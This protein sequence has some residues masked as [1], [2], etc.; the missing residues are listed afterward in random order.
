MALLNIDIRKT[1]K[2]SVGRNTPT[3]KFSTSGEDWICKKL[4][5]L[6]FDYHLGYY[7]TSV[8][9]LN[10]FTLAQPIEPWLLLFDTVLSLTYNKE[11]I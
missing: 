7:S 2:I 11:I 9:G 4:K 8:K 3:Q 5:T 1:V 6:I 10:Q